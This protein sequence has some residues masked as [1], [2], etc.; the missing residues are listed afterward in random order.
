MASPLFIFKIKQIHQPKFDGY[1]KKNLIIANKPKKQSFDVNYRAS[2]SGIN[3]FLPWRT[4]IQIKILYRLIDYGLTNTI[5]S[6][7]FKLLTF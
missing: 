5:S 2:L 6:Y 7:I 4:L 1:R 3:R